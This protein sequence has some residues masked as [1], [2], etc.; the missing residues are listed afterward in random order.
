MS[1]RST[2]FST[3]PSESQVMSTS[4]AR[5][6]GD[7]FKRWMGMTGKSWSSAQ[8]SGSDWKTEKLQRYLSTSFD[9]SSTNSSATN[10]AVFEKRTALERSE[11]HT[12]ELQSRLH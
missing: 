3:S 11:E 1:F 4:V 12:S 10:F 2:N 5:R 7:S 6:V 9:S 8:W